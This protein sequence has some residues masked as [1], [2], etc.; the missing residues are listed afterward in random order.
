M[1]NVSD[2]NGV[3]T[4]T[5]NHPESLNSLTEPLAEAL[6]AAVKETQSNESVRCLII[7]G[8]GKAFCAGGNLKDFLGLE[9]SKSDY[10]ADAMERLYNPI[11]DLLYGLE[12]PVLTAVNGPAIGAGFGL[13][14]NADFVFANRSAFFSLPFVPMLGVVPDNGSSWLLANTLGYQK[15]LGLMLSGDKLTA[16]DAMASGLV[17]RCTE[18]GSVLEEATA[19]AQ[20]LA[21]LPKDASA[22]AK[23]MLRAAAK[24]SFSEQ[25]DV[26]KEHQTVCFGGADFEEG[27]KAFTERRKPNFS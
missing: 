8:A 25:L 12:I 18:D 13:A 6:L 23:K 26:E 3:R 2:A 17:Y 20:T 14:L 10:I 4:I 24:N 16:E 11:V 22:R 21:A 1:I 7:T 15:A 19:F 5:L 9:T 27:L